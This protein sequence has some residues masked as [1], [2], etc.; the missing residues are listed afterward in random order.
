MGCSACSVRDCGIDHRRQIH[1]DPG[2]PVRA[3]CRRR[4]L[5][6]LSGWLLILCPSMVAVRSS[7]QELWVDLSGMRELAFDKISAP[8]AMHTLQT[9][10][11]TW[12]LTKSL[13]TTPDGRRSSASRAASFGPAC[14]SSIVRNYACIPPSD[15]GHAGG[16][17]LRVRP[18]QAQPGDEVAQQS[19]RSSARQHYSNTASISR[20]HQR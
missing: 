1:T 15:H 19:Q 18:Q 6:I 17:W 10:D 9:R 3:H 12:G 5:P 13:H 16:F 11:F 8:H 20:H 7:S 14:V 4:A 2:S